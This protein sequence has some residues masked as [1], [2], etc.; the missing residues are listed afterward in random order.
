MEAQ[1]NR[2]ARRIN[3]ALLLCGMLL[4]ADA[5]AAKPVGGKVFATVGNV[6]ITWAEYRNEYISESNNKFYHAKPAEDALASFQREVADKLVEDAILVQEAKRRKIKPD[7]SAV[8]LELQ[9]YDQKFAQDPKWPKARKRVLPI[10]TKDLQ[11]K[12]IRD[13]LEALV[14][15]IP[16]PKESELHA[17]YESHMDKFTSPVQIRVSVILLRMDPGS[18]AEEW[19]KA[20]EE[21]EGLVKR[22]RAGEDFAELARDYS[23][24]ITAE[25]GGDMGF[26]HGGMLPGLPEETV[27]KLQ[28]GEIADPVTLLE[29]VAIFKLTN[30]TQP[31]ANSF[32]KSRQRISELWLTEHRDATWDSFIA[33]LRKKTPVHIDESRFLPL[34]ATTPEPVKDGEKSSP[35]A[36]NY[37]ELRES[38]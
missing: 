29:G 30:R 33:K 10:I 25:E 18:S 7:D 21:A 1:K 31:E 35:P 23:G 14:R 22:L 34:K 38:H 15:N 24:D 12:S 36:T 37:N 2:N 4:C 27:N 3:L 32:E 20:K 28:P 6:E 17:Y 26:L 19:N 5:I 13:K 9:K 8:N 11:N 16:P